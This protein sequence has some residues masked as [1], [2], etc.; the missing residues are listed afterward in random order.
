MSIQ[1]PE[2]L[3]FQAYCDSLMAGY[4]ATV[5]VYFDEGVDRIDLPAAGIRVLEASPLFDRHTGEV[6]SWRYTIL[7]AEMSVLDMLNAGH[8]VH[9]FRGE[10]TERL[11]QSC[12]LREVDGDKRFLLCTND[13]HSLDERQEATYRAWDAAVKDLGGDEALK[14]LLDQQAAEWAE[15]LRSTGEMSR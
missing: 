15:N 13:P 2:R 12:W 8:P 3:A 5:V 4:G 14:A 1:E 11:R 9:V 6:R 7:F 10:V